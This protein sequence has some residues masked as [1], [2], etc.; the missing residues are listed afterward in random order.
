MSKIEWTEKT[1]NPIAGCSIISQ[2]CQNCYAM[3]MAHRLAGIE[4]TKEK[5]GGLTHKTTSGKVIWNREV[6][7]DE[8]A[9]LEPLKRKKPTMYFVNSMS[10]LFYEKVPDK[11]I[12]KA[13]AIMALCPQHTF[14]VLSKRAD[15]MKNYFE[16]ERT[17]GRIFSQIQE[18]D[19]C[20]T[21]EIKLLLNGLPLKNG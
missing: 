6:K 17:H 4:A 8:K 16:D 19:I 3:T 9:L 21:Q 14:Q 15:R 7:F 1:W 11:W 18:M 20:Q 13:F 5:Y 10:D 2:G 12:D